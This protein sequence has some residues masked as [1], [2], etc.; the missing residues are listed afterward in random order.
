MDGA[1]L[2][3][4]LPVSGLLVS[5]AKNS[6]MSILWT[7]PGLDGHLEFNLKTKVLTLL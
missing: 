3:S 2:V 7:C 4:L 6:A 5:L 1:E